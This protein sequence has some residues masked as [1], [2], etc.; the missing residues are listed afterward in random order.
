M[1]RGRRRRRRRRWA[2]EAA[3][4]C[5]PLP[6]A[7]AL[8]QAGEADDISISSSPEQLLRPLSEPH[9]GAWGLAT[10]A[11]VF[12]SPPPTAT[13]PAAEGWCAYRVEDWWTYEVCYE[14][15][16]RQYHKEGAALISEY[17]L[18][19]Y[20]EGETGVNAV[21]ARPGGAR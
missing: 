16:V 21:Q 1:V 10:R 8:L 5:E 4:K 3:R 20:D 15:H 12:A 17:L 13:C 19:T 2:R 6:C 18:G 14:R 9:C 11:C 7:P